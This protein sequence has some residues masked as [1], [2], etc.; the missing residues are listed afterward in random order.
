MALPHCSGLSSSGI[1]YK[2]TSLIPPTPGTTLYYIPVCVCVCVCMHTHA[3]TCM[4]I[5]FWMHEKKCIQVSVSFLFSVSSDRYGISLRTESMTNG[6]WVPEPCLVHWNTVEAQ[7]IYTEW[8]N[9][10]LLSQIL[11]SVL[12]KPHIKTTC[13]FC[14]SQS[15]TKMS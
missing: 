4:P 13:T 9:N 11:N 6:P 2:T 3:H 14:I 10:K 15:S 8:E 5:S 12:S 1:S 7:Q